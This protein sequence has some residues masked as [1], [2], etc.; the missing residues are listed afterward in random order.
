M[1]AVRTERDVADLLV[2]RTSEVEQLR[3]FVDR[4]VSKVMFVHGVAGVGKSTLLRCFASLPDVDANVHVLDCREIEPTPAGFH[5]ATASLPAFAPSEG[6][7][8]ATPSGGAPRVVVCLDQYEVLR[9]LDSWI[10]T[11][12]VAGLFDRCSLVM[13]GREAP[14]PAWHRLPAA[15]FETMRLGPLDPSAS[16][17]LVRR[18]GVGEAHLADIVRLASGHPLT[19]VLGS[20]AAREGAT[21]HWSDVVMG[22]LLDEFAAAY[23]DELG[24]GE[25]RLLEAAA[26]VRRVTKP[27]LRAL[28]PDTD[29]DEGFAAL[30]SM[31]FVDFSVDGLA[32]HETIQQA[33]ISHLRAA[34][35]DRYRTLRRR[36][37]AHLRAE[38]RGPPREQLWR[39]TADMIYLVED[40]N[41]REAHFPSGAYRF[42]IEEATFEDGPAIHA[43]IGRHETPEAAD[44][45]QEWWR[46]HP[47]A[48]RVARG[49]DSEVAGFSIIATGTSAELR[50]RAWDPLA[51]VWLDHLADNPIPPDSLLILIR[52]WLTWDHG[53]LPCEAQAC[54]WLDLKRTYMELRP[55]LRRNYGVTDHPEVF[56]PVME[57]LRGGRIAGPGVDLGGRM[58]HGL[59]L[60][61]GPSSVDGWLSLLAADELGLM[62]DGVVDVRLR[63]LIVDGRRVDLTPLEF[64]VIHYL[65]EHAGQPVAR[66]DLLANIWGYEAE[67]GSNVVD[68]VVHALRKKLGR[69]CA[70][71]ETIRGVGYRL[72]D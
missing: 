38:L 31:A 19:L 64:E 56:G 48:F 63:Q 28:E 59:F 60:E 13:A 37:W 67:I 7:V 21:S 36:A 17:A 42:A 72:A 52:R 68:V 15:T 51:Q 27:L 61:F 55:R 25:M 24:A 65:C 69:D 62:D 45:L 70:R 66:R 11:H 54:L 3:D 16:A 49:A 53:D 14:H 58:Y 4:R 22:R 43:I 35:P 6:S 34:D 12:L 39:H 10:R 29:P 32:I 57:G 5:A 20:L 1:N 46:R 8:P 47:M 50:H 26:I 33:I 23:F 2:G 18:F 41:V 71:L 44:L 30:R 40:R 9:L